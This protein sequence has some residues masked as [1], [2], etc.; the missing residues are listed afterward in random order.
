MRGIN[1]TKQQETN[2]PTK[3]NVEGTEQSETK[4]RLSYLW[5]RGMKRRSNI[6]MKNYNKTRTGAA[7]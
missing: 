3:K 2:T 1:L 6:Q 7:N 4:S 5:G